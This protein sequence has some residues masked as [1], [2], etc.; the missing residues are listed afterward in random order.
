V[1]KD[2]VIKE[3]QRKREKRSTEREEWESIKRRAGTDKKMATH[4]GKERFGWR[5]WEGWESQLTGAR[6]LEHV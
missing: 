5:E 3:R 1:K 4:M 2:A 6:I